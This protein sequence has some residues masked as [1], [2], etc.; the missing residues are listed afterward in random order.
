MP[1]Q[2][3]REDAPG[4]EVFWLDEPLVRAFVIAQEEKRE[5]E[6]LLRAHGNAALLAAEEGRDYPDVLYLSPDSRITPARAWA[7]TEQV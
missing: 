5:A 4:D 3:S 2:Q 7:V 6:R 1:E